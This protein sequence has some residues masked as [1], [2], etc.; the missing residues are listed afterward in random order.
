MGWSDEKNLI[1]LFLIISLFVTVVINEI[2]GLIFFAMFVVYYIGISTN[3]AIQFDVKGGNWGKVIINAL[4]S[5]VLFYLIAGATLNVLQVESS[6]R[7]I[8]S[9]MATSAA[10]FGIS[11]DNDLVKFL[12]W[13][14][15]IP[16]AETVFFLGYVLPFLEK[17]MKANTSKIVDKLVILLVLGALTALFHLVSH[18]AANEALIVDIVFFAVSGFVV[19][20]KKKGWK[21]SIQ[22]KSAWLVHVLLN[23]TAMAIALGWISQIFGVII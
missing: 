18:L 13:G 3:T 14:V 20:F 8:M 6:W 17:N 9:I 16:T 7:N 5:L 22:M 19:L 21:Q 4:A 1:G 23:S 12:I 2:L 15:Y 11:I 10:D